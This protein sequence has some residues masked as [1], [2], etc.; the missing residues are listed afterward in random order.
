MSGYNKINGDY[1]GGNH[2]LITEVLK[3]AWGYQGW[4]MSDWGATPSWE[5]ALKGLDQEAGAN[6]DAVMWKNEPLTEP[7]RKAYA[8][9]KLPKERLSDMV[10]RILRSMYAVGVDKWGPAPKVDMARHNE[11]ALET[12]RQGIVLLKNDGVLPLAADSGLR[13]AVIGGHAQVGVPTGTG[14]TAVTPPG[15]GMRTSSG[16]R[17]GGHGSGTQPLPAPLVTSREAEEA[18]CP[19]RR[20]SSTR[21]GAR[22]RP[23]SWRGAR[24][25]SSSSGFA[26]RA[27]ASISPI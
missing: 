23:Y 25:W 14:S 6:L 11:I 10:R 8:E 12:A 16:W 18:S 27:K 19:R 13:I 2:Y 22:R 7:L 15:V 5:F 4:V 24:M 3:G 17:S 21:A 1:A 9:G 26:W 20:S